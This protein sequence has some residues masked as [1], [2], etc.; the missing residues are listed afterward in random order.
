MLELTPA[1]MGLTLLNVLVLMLILKKFLYQPVLDIIRKRE[2]LISSQFSS[3][4]KAQDEADQMKV[5]YEEKL[6]NAK[7]TAEEL[8][9]SA[10]ERAEKERAAALEE[11]RREQEMIVNKAKAD[12]ANERERAKVDAEAEIAALALSAA[13]KIVQSGE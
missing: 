13:R 11:T 2:E 6:A 10:K 1:S 5:D 4:K 3:A 12:I 8:V 7:Q 9:T